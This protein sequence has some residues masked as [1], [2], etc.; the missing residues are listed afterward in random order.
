MDN[1]IYVIY[2]FTPNNFS[3]KIFTSREL[4]ETD[5][6]LKTLEPN[7]VERNKNYY[8][9]RFIDDDKKYVPPIVY[10]PSELWLK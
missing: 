10:L 3:K 4:I 7:P 2:K 5:K 8:I 1:Y 6:Q 9:A